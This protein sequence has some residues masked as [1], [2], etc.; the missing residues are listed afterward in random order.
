MAEFGLVKKTDGDYA[1]LEL[2]R[3]EACKHCMSVCLL[4]RQ[5]YDASSPKR[6]QSKSRRLCQRRST[7]GWL[8][9]RSLL[10]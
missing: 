8:S 5:S 10:S 3:S 1:V 9:V 7:A 2:T 6:L 4:N